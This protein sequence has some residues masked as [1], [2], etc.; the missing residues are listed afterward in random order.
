MLLNVGHANTIGA[1]AN[2]E[3]S[4]GLWYPPDVPGAAPDN[5]TVLAVLADGM[6]GHAGGAVAS[7]VACAT[8]IQVFEL[9]GGA[10]HDRL[11][12][13]LEVCNQAISE[14][15]AQDPQLNGMGSTIVAAYVDREGLRWVSVGDSL[16]YLYRNGQLQRLNDDHSLGRLLDIQA[17]RNQI[18][19][20]EAKA[21]RHRNALRSALTGKKLEIIDRHHDPVR[22][23]DGD[24]IVLASDGIATLDDR[25]IEAL[26]E[27]NIRQ[28][29]DE[30][31]H[32][33]I[34]AVERRG[35]QGQDNTTLILVK[36]GNGAGAGF[37]TSPTRI[38]RSRIMPS[39]EVI[40]R[41]KRVNAQAP[42]APSGNYLRAFG[43]A[44]I[45]LAVALLALIGGVSVYRSLIEPPAEQGSGKTTAPAIVE[46]PTKER[47]G[48]PTPRPAD[49]DT[50]KI[51][52][53]PEAGEGGGSGEG[54]GA[55]PAP[56]ESGGSKDRPSAK[57]G[58]S[59]KIPTR[60][61]EPT[62]G[63]AEGAAPGGGN[64]QPGARPEQRG[65]PP[66]YEKKK[67]EGTAVPPNRSAELDPC[68]TETTAEGYCACWKA[69]ARDNRLPVDEVIRDI[70]PEPIR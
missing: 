44:T 45:G 67:R 32:Q 2:Q 55:R 34:T 42:A 50:G 52:S 18:S 60:P 5:E 65:I 58:G 6:G 38:V 39:A 61:G 16:L 69:Y 26:I 19:F 17:E 41:P 23:Q 31:A 28:E 1:R 3:D 20:E 25:E 48:K 54:G 70:C 40:T 15:V 12:S 30:V 8:F 11:E 62:P 59:Q 10:L 9:S 53:K 46:P 63:P 57:Q 29:P 51:E 27:R 47:D 14:H 49:K 37:Q 66:R 7:A 64:E 24:W 68:N 35:V 22:L 4:A 36:V 13:S 33:I 56:P 43:L 21:H